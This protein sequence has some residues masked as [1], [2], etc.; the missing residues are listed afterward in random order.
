MKINLWKRSHFFLPRS[1]RLFSFLFY[2]WIVMEERKNAF[3]RIPWLVSIFSS[4]S[5]V[6][7]L[8]SV[9]W[10]MKRNASHERSRNRNPVAIA[11]ILLSSFSLGS[12]DSF[13]FF[14][15]V[16]PKRKTRMIAAMPLQDYQSS[17]CTS[18]LSFLLNQ[19]H[20]ISREENNKRK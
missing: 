11:V 10:I 3:Q 19:M 15:Y 2:V 7:S 20:L 16:E 18:S 14:L 17:L 8:M 1:T 6:F 13:L 4:S 9:C 5:T 12:T